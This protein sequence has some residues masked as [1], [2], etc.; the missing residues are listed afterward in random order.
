[1]MYHVGMAAAHQAPGIPGSRQGLSWL[2]IKGRFLLAAVCQ[3][4]FIAN[5]IFGCSSLTLAIGKRS[6]KRADGVTLFIFSR[7]FLAPTTGALA[8]SL[9]IGEVISLHVVAF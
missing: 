8:T 1:M 7:V 2:V 6:C 5:S 4:P 9:A 3:T